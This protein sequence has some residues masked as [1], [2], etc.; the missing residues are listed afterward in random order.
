MRLYAF[1]SQVLTFADA[2]LEKLYV[3]ARHLRRLV[4]LQGETL[5]KEVQQNIDMETYR[6]QETSSGRIALDRK[7]GRLDPVQTK[8]HHTPGEEQ[9]EPLS[10]II[11][12]LNERFGL[13][14]GPEHSATLNLIMKKLDGDAA[15][16][17]SARVNTRENVRLSFDH[18]VEDVIQGIVESDFDLYKRITDDRVRRNH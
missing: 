14:L 1:L 10:R 7:A 11:A 16:D 17:A 18:K 2:D 4:T 13:N 12:E 3:F 9:M 5:P 6:I 15:L 8:N